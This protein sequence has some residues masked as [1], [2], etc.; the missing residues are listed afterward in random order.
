M[1]ICAT[2]FQRLPTLCNSTLKMTTLFR[3]CL[4]LFL[5][6]LKYT[7][8]IRRWKF[9]RW[10]TQRCFNV[11]STFPTLRRR[12]NQKTTLKER[13]NVC[14]VPISSLACI[15]FASNLLIYT[16]V[17]KATTFYLKN[18]YLQTYLVKF[19]TGH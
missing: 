3:R 18:N 1:V 13:W 5:S 9:Q 8:L 17:L 12:I 11:D 15:D 4:K 19:P 14:W 6:T 10:N 2:L 7:T 16:D